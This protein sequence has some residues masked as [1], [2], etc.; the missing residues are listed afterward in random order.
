MLSQFANVISVIDMSK[1]FDIY[2]SRAGLLLNSIFPQISNVKKTITVLDCINITIKQGEAVGLIGFN[3]AGKSTLLK[4][5]AGVI[6]PTHGSVHIN[7]RINAIL[8][9]GMGFHPDFSGFE[10]AELALRLQGI[11]GDLTA[12]INEIRDFSEVGEYF[13]QPVRLY[14]SGM[15]M[16]LAFSVATAIRP[17]IL[18]IDEA[19][20]VGD[21]YFQHKSFDRIKSFK[22]QGTS[23]IFVSHDN[24]AVL[25]LCDTAILIDKGHIIKKGHAADI[26]DFYNAMLSTDPKDVSQKYDDSGQLQ[27]QFGTN[28]IEI[29]DCTIFDHNGQDTQVL[30]TGGSYQLSIRGRCLSS[31]TD[32]VCGILIKDRYGRIIFGTNTH[33]TNSILASFD[34][35]EVAEFIFHFD[36]NFGE[37]EYSISV[38]FHKYETHVEKNFIWIDRLCLFKVLNVDKNPFIGSNF[39]EVRVEIKK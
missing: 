15:I 3:G 18:I 31:L 19:L 11:H 13:D 6:K 37:G 30:S 2:Q 23:I 22:A 4:I 39:L 10:N 36:A 29:L 28:E 38:A 5:I 20:S 9:L 27:T 14:S 25:N 33:N 32:I 17:E 1:S 24:A 26:L 12:I 35:G 16:R 7:G 8:E 34:E 21:V